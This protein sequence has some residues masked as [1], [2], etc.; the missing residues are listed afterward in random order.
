MV[1]PSGHTFIVFNGEIYNYC[2]LRNSLIA[3]GVAFRTASDTEVI[4]A[5][6]EKYGVE[7]L[8]FLRGMF[9]F[10]IWDAPRRK[11]ILARDRLG[12]KPIYYVSM[13]ERFLFASE[14]KALRVVAEPSQIEMDTDSLDQY[15]S[16]G[17]ISGPQ[18]IYRGIMQLPPA[19]VLI[20]TTP[21]CIAL[22]HYWKPL[23]STKRRISFAEAVNEAD[24]RITEAVQLRL[25]ADVPIGAFLS[26]GI[27]S[28][29]IT[30]IASK[31]MGKPF[32]TFT[33]GF[34]DSGFDERPLAAGVSRQYGTDHHEIVLRPDLSDLLP[35][36][37]R[38][39]D[40]PFADASAIP[41]FCI[42]RFVREQRIKVVLNGD[43][44]DELFSGYRRDL[45]SA[46]LSKI[47][48]IVGEGG[49]T[50]VARMLEKIMPVPRTHRSRYALGHRFVRGAA[51]SS[52]TRMLIWSSDGFTMNEKIELQSRTGESQ[53]DP[54][55]LELYLL[56]GD[57]ISLLDHTIGLNLLWMLPHALL[58]KMDVATMANGLEA[59]SPF[60]DHELVE[61]AI[62]LPDH[63]R[64]PGF[65]T[66]P[67]LRRLAR[68]YL[69]DVA[70]GAPK[71][72]F[73]IP[74][75]RWLSRDLKDMRD[76]LL[77]SRNGLVSAM[78]DRSRLERFLLKIPGGDPDRWAQLVW[79]L[80]M[81]AAWDC[82]VVKADEV[83]AQ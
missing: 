43:G 52:P 50:R 10:A 2:E 26:G 55:H 19:T 9:A 37:A 79:T 58:V 72:G 75:H 64:L 83:P 7:C 39:Y 61:W 42:A 60:L 73:E 44:G 13:R 56:A 6:Y 59:R 29:I 30:A 5:L 25:R 49:I 24:R 8:R 32:P 80:L 51:A 33:V 68:N 17:F 21:G 27:D 66:K 77:L 4:L 20:A 12:K 54:G 57:G 18:T 63:V 40:Q 28:G 47:T 76:D 48:G 65:T 78:F 71:R 22:D 53:L 46:W 70:C 14:I 38:A 36:I 74:L 45:A 62:S 67:I 69:P 41:T 23:W 15:L 11:L 35:Q 16:Y 3:E 31:H 81:L 1:G 82:Y 34:E